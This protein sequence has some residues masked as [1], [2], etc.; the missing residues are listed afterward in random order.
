M[1]FQQESR[2]QVVRG[3]PT[4]APSQGR[5]SCQLPPPA[6]TCVGSVHSEPVGAQQF[7]KETKMVI[8]SFGDQR[9]FTEGQGCGCGQGK[10]GK[11][12]PEGQASK[13]QQQGT[14][15]TIILQRGRGQRGKVGANSWTHPTCNASSG[16]GVQDQNSV[17]RNGV[18]LSSDPSTQSAPHHITHCKRA[19]R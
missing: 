10:K 8:S 9:E 5:S 13:G 15:S 18:L 4:G 7:Y 19:E 6:G 14:I 1:S 3:A 16:P 17:Q 11:V 2:G 12:S